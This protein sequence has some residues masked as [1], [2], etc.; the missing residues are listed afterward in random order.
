[1]KESGAKS[2]TAKKV[3]TNLFGRRTKTTL[4]ASNYLS[5]EMAKKGLKNPNQHSPQ[6]EVKRDFVD[7][8]LATIPY[9]NTPHNIASC[10]LLRLVTDTLLEGGMSRNKDGNFTYNSPGITLN[11]WPS[12]EMG[13]VTIPDKE[14]TASWLDEIEPATL[15]THLLFC[16][17]VMVAAPD[18]QRT[19][20]VRARDIVDFLGLINNKKDFRNNR[21]RVDYVLGLATH[22]GR[23]NYVLS[24]NKNKKRIDFN[25]S[26]DILWKVE[27]IEE[28]SYKDTVIT[29]TPGKWAEKFLNGSPFVEYTT[30]DSRIFQ[31]IKEHRARRAYI[32]RLLLYFLYQERANNTQGYGPINCKAKKLLIEMFGTKA[33]NKALRNMRTRRSLLERFYNALDILKEK[34]LVYFDSEETYTLEERFLGDV[35]DEPSKTKLTK[36]IFSHII[37]QS[38]ILSRWPTDRKKPQSKEIPLAEI[39]ERRQKLGFTQV[40]F[41]ARIGVNHNTYKSFENGFRKLPQQGMKRLKEIMGIPQDVKVVAYKS[42]KKLIL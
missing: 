3:S 13:K 8:P 31:I 16:T 36:E 24:W 2:N 1:M 39:K 7:R 14:V 32:V 17:L 26:P 4:L 27:V 37:D 22:L 33:F 28:S 6:R 15:T 41:A 38:I 23:V 34:G 11:L 42:D 9:G 35:D 18:K 19:F 29:V 21:E 30:I 40:Q 10:I 25:I 5:S 12:K 20:S